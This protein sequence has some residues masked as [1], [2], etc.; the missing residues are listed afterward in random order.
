MTF[1]VA[2]TSAICW[3]DGGTLWLESC[4][5]ELS[6][7]P[8]LPQGL[9]PRYSHQVK[10][11]KE[12]L[13][14]A[15]A[16]AHIFGESLRRP[17]VLRAVQAAAGRSCGVHW[18]SPGTRRVRSVPGPSTYDWNTRKDSFCPINSIF[19][20]A[21]AGCGAAPVQRGWGCPET[22]TASSS[23]SPRRD[24]AEPSPAAGTEG[25]DTARQGGKLGLGRRVGPILQV[26]ARRRQ[27]FLN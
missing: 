13:N 7:V 11:T 22:D 3:S 21:W 9:P 15:A 17:A 6:A 1:S 18:H 27:H 8:L 14:P 24:T 10:R 16:S 4:A 19:G 12:R 23:W 5:W 20:R 2:L 26:L 25:T